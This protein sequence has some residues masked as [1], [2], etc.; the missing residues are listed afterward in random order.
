MHHAAVG[1]SRVNDASVRMAFLVQRRCITYVP[2]AARH[3]YDHSTAFAYGKG[4]KA[5]CPLPLYTNPSKERVPTPLRTAPAV[6]RPAGPSH[7]TFILDVYI[8]STYT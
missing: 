5:L 6:L 4:H 8:I 2:A 1:A 3:I 7:T